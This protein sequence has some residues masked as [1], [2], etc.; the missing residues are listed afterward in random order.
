MTVTSSCPSIDLL[1]YF[2]YKNFAFVLSNLWYAFFC[3][4]SAQVRIY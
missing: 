3:A 1:S 2:F 4:F